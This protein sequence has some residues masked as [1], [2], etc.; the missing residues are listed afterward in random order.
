V[1]SS[2]RLIEEEP[3]RVSDNASQLARN[4]SLAERTAYEARILKNTD[5]TTAEDEDI[6]LYKLMQIPMD[7]IDACGLLRPGAFFV[8]TQ[9]SDRQ[10]YNVEVSI[11]VV[12][13]PESFMSGCFRVPGLTEDRPILTTYFEAEIIGPKFSFRTND[14]WGATKSDDVLHWRRFRHFRSRQGSGKR[15]GRGKQGSNWSQVE[16]L[17]DLRPE[18]WWEERFIYMRWKEFHLTDNPSKRSIQGA[19]LEGFY[20]IALDQQS[21]RIGGTHYHLKAE[22]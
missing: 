12:S 8:G 9:K 14:N 6:E 3:A 4:A 20:Y 13:V 1:P 2:R 21:A 10:I 22:K 19:S 15:Q 18:R 5:V 11:I 17:E 7:G 16:D